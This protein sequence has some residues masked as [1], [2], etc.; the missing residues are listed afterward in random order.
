MRRRRHLLRSA[1]NAERLLKAI[2]ELERDEKASR[3]RARQETA[4][5]KGERSGKP[6]P[7]DFDEFLEDK[8]KAAS[9]RQ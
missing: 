6:E 4:L 5:I 3:Q 2:G 7:F 8:R 9:R 1:K